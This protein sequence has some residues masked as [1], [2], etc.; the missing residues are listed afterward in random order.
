MTN[1]HSAD[2]QCLYLEYFGRPADVA[3]LA[4]WTSTLETGAATFAGIAQS[5]SQ[6]A[7]YQ[8]YSEGK[9]EYARVAAVYRL[10]FGHNPDVDGMTFWGQHLAH[11]DVALDQVVTAI[12]GGAQGADLDVLN[13][14]VTA[15]LAFTDALVEYDYPLYYEHNE[16]PG[17]RF[18][19]EVTDDASL[20]RAIDPATLEHTL[21]VMFAAYSPTPSSAH[22]SGGGFAMAGPAA[23]EGDVADVAGIVGTRTAMPDA[24]GV[25]DILS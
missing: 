24:S 16:A 6:S 13:N 4:F 12:A 10:L 25:H 7:E 22:E 23:P 8:S 20:A 2:I 9:S 17:M 18:L 11:G 21:W 19:E 14:K 15:A 5:F 3:G 1:T